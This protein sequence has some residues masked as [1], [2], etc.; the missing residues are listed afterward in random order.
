M[1]L[2]EIKAIQIA[3]SPSANEQKL[4]YRPDLEG[5]VHVYS[6]GK[7]EVS[8]VN[9]ESY[10]DFGEVYKSY[11]WVRKAIKV[12]SDAIKPRVIKVLDKEGQEISMHPIAELFQYVNDTEYAHDLWEKWVVDKMLGG[13]CFFEFVMNNSGN[14][15]VEIWARGPEEVLVVPDISQ[16]RIFYPRVAGYRYIVDEETLIEPHLI[17]HD[18]FLNPLNRWRG[19][20]VI[21]AVRMGIIIDI[22]SQ[23][24][25]QTFLKRGA[26]PDWALIAPEGLTPTEKEELTDML[27]EKFG[28]LSGWHTPMILEQGVTDIKSLNWTPKDTEWLA[29]RKISRDEVGGMFGVPDA[30]MGYG[31]EAYDNSERIDAN[32]MFFWRFTAKPLI[33]SRDQALTNFFT[34][35]HKLLSNGERVVTDLSGVAVLQED[36]D[37]KRGLFSTYWGAGVPFDV[38]NE[39]F[40]LELPE[41]DGSDQGYLPTSVQPANQS[42]VRRTEPPQQAFDIEQISEKV[43]AALIG[44]MKRT[45]VDVPPTIIVEREKHQA[46]FAALLKKSF[47]SMQLEI[48]SNLR[49]S[50][51]KAVSFEAADS[52]EK[53][54]ESFLEANLLENRAD[55]KQIVKQE[56]DK[57]V[58]GEWKTESEVNEAF[59]V[60]KSTPFAN[61][62]AIQIMASILKN[63][64]KFE[65]GDEAIDPLLNR[66]HRDFERLILRAVR[67]SISQSSFEEEAQSIL[68]PE[69]RE[70]FEIG[71]DIPSGE[72]WEREEE[73][74]H[75]E[76][77]ILVVAAIATLSSE[78]YEQN[79]YAANESQTQAEAEQKARNRVINWVAGVALFYTIGQIWN[80]LNPFMVFILGTAIDHCETCLRL[81]GQVHRSLDWRLSGLYPRSRRLACGGWRC[82]CRLVKDEDAQS[83]TGEF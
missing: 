43:V 13:E 45:V 21:A 38:L 8:I 40:G 24:W 15:P 9:S 73:E 27:L 28:G 46:R 44:K 12:I 80:R 17:W 6:Q 54:A 79:R 41:F 57:R 68:L 22:F 10:Q 39:H 30:L 55:I 83:P 74:A 72:E 2:D 33:D 66:F 82:D 59:S 23:S 71:A 29:Q 64:T 53:A 5:R 26:R 25:S 62:L 76:E 65:L 69:S 63:A 75:S 50:T 49:N 19:L 42:G 36:H 18:K 58:K 78:I 4:S 1:Y 16:E 61:A 47:Q 20:S 67:N 60:L 3:S 77:Y 56:V 48:L 31:V 7:D 11:V 37:K 35:H 52:Y 51:S 14:R 81:H 34:K 32:T 70:A